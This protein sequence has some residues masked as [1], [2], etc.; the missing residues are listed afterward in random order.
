MVA[1]PLLALL[2]ATVLFGVAL[3]QDRQAQ[4]AVLHTVEVERQI[5]HV[6]IQVQ[7]GVTGYVLTGERRYLTSYETARRELP[8]AVGQLG[9]LVSDNPG[10]MDRVERVRALV[11]E[12]AD[13]LEALVANVQANRP[14]ASRAE[15]LDQNKVSGDALIA[16]LQ[17]MQDSEQRLLSVRQA[18]ARRARTLALGAIG[19]SVLLGIAGGIAAVLLF[20][21]GVTRRAA[22]LEQNADRLAG[23]LPLLPA[24]PGSDALGELGRG[25]ERAAVLLGERERALREAQALLEHI[26]AWSPMV[27]FRGLL[28]GSGE[29]YVSGNVERLLGYT[30]EQVLGTPSFWADQLHPEDRERFTAMLERAVVE[31]APQLEQEYR[32]LLQ[33]GYR[34]L[35]GVTR[36]VYDDDGAL[37]DTLGYAMDVTERK[38]A[39]D[40]VREREATLQAVINAS[41]DIIT[42]LDADGAIR[43]MSPAAQRILGR[44]AETRMG[45]SALDS[46]FVHP[47]DLERFAHAQRQLLSGERE[48]AAVRVRV[49]H[50]E[51]HWLTLEAHSRPLAAPE[52]LLVVV[53]RRHR[54]GQ[55]GGGPAPGQARRRAGQRGQERVPVAH[56]PRAADAAERH[57]RVR[58][59]AGPGRP[60]TPSSATTSA[61]SCRGRGTCSASSTRCSTSPPSRPDGCRCRWSR[62][63][64]PTWPPRPVS[65][66]RPA[67][68][69][70]PASSWSARNVGRAPPTSSATASGSSRSC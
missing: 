3:A 10:Q 35:Y 27:M 62:S 39:D 60:R 68:R 41:P 4:D 28:G 20:T 48:S 54:A 5:A 57:P 61:T 12:R 29:R 56:E 26:V 70:A 33:D 43:S 63:P 22:R 16:Q 47:D 24:L 37:A 31:R 49:R 17:A 19:L 45:R 9:D 40:A 42:I 46:E 44:Q 32:F 7:A 30:Q 38:Q 65:L 21:S 14:P 66:I 1:I 23:G 58:P 55:A 53:P 50:A 64:W 59:A 18:Q 34:W 6:R 8:E 25:L 52:G 11:D 2:L 51:G 13:L 36:L 69:P 15:L 67:G